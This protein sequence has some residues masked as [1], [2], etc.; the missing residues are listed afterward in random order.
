MGVVQWFGW[1]EGFEQCVGVLGYD[2][3][4]SFIVGCGVCNCVLLCVFSV[5]VVGVL[6]C[7]CG[8]W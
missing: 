7:W 6:G 4:L 2:G 3:F 8:C 1:I 5:F